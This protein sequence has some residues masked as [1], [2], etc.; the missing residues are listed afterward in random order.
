MRFTLISLSVLLSSSVALV[1]RQSNDVDTSTRVIHTSNSSSVIPSRNNSAVIPNSNSSNPLNNHISSG[2]NHPIRP[3]QDSLQAK[4]NK[5]EVKIARYRKEIE[6]EEEKI[7]K[8][9]SKQ[10]HESHEEKKNHDDKENHGDKQDHDEKK[11]GK[12]GKHDKDD[13]KLG[14]VKNSTTSAMNGTS[15]TSGKDGISTDLM[16]NGTSTISTA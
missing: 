3:T 2:P 12:D 13:H 8:L 7:S 1:V 14:S 15:S 16:M 4:I 10:Q 9:K 11:P 6:H 5:L